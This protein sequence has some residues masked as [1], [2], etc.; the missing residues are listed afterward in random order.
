MDPST[1][2]ERCPFRKLPNELICSIFESTCTDNLLQESNKFP[3]SDFTELSSPVITYTPALAISTVCAQ[4]R[5]LALAL[6]RLWS[7]LTLEIASQRARRS[8]YV[9]SG[10][11]LTL[12]LFLDRSAD[13]PLRIDYKTEKNVVEY[14]SNPV[15]LNLLLQ[16]SCRWQSFSYTGYYALSHCKGFY[17]RLPFPILEHISLDSRSLSVD[18]DCFERA[19][20]VRSVK[21]DILYKDSCLPWNQLTSMD[22]RHILPV[23]SIDIHQCSNLTSLILRSSYAKSICGNIS[24]DRLESL[25]FAFSTRDRDLLRRILDACTFS[26]LGEL[27]ITPSISDNLVWPVHA[28]D[29]FVSRSSCILTRLSISGVEIS[30][31]DLLAAFRILP[32]LVQFAFSDVKHP[33]RL[34][35]KSR[36]IT[37]H[38]ISCMHA[39]FSTA[40]EILVPKLRTLSLTLLST[41][42]DDAA[43]TSM[44]SSRWLPDPVSSAA[45]GVDCLRSLVL[46]LLER[47]VDKEMYRPLN[48]MDRMGM[49]VVVV[50]KSKVD[51]KI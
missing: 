26:S 25:T 43:F 14:Q 42:F 1:D 23:V 20:N 39:S 30:D 19:P 47:E 28:F 21:A 31:L 27:I 5:S 7:Q 38:F 44:I 15:A 40:S 51:D 3:S 16:H 46:H 24:L 45:I 4:W 41:S 12:H 34:A 6:P 2:Y 18:L 48:D 50:G 8:Y 37:S 33:R 32:Y 36:P 13:S 17:P 11:I 10:F 22:I 49:R 29:A 9:P 35:K